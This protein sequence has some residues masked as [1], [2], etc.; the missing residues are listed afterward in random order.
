MNKPFLLAL[1]MS[2]GGAAFAAGDVK[3]GMAGFTKCA[4]CH[5][6]GPNAK[7]GFGPQLTGIIG[8]PAAAAKDYNYSEA[9]KKSGI[10]WSDKL[11][12]AFM[13]SPT[14]VVPG[15][16]MRFWGISNENQLADLLA[17]LKSVQ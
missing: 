8:R 10:V 15:T 9:M 12:V 13:K 2:V 4:S 11:L 5:Q 17:Y 1:L 6:V 3:A 16:K 14:D 7:S